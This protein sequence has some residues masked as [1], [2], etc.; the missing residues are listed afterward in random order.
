MHCMRR[1][2]HPPYPPFAR[3][4]K[5]YPPFARGG[6]SYPPFARGGKSYPPFARGGKS[7]P[8]FARGGK[9]YPPFA[10]GGKS[11][12]P[13][14]RGGKSYPP[15]A[16]GGK[17]AAS[18][19]FSPLA[20]GGHRG[21]LR[22]PR[23]CARFGIQAIEKRSRSSRRSGFRPSQAP[24]GQRRRR[25]RPPDLRRVWVDGRWGYLLAEIGFG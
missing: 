10:R 2:S 8:P 4:G 13:F 11:Y 3:G 9:S 16:R 5:S 21:V 19:L 22:V 24:R 7:Y 1:G 15:F 14:A 17:S 18:G 20:K 23:R 6:K 12:P 25:L